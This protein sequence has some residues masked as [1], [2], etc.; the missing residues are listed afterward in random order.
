ML[1]QLRLRFTF[2]SHKSK[3]EFQSKLTGGTDV[4]TMS[5]ELG[6]VLKANGESATLVREVTILG[7]GATAHSA[8]FTHLSKDGSDTCDSDNDACR[9]VLVEATEQGFNAAQAAFIRSLGGLPDP[10]SSSTTAPSVLT[11]IK[12]FQLLPGGWDGRFEGVNDTLWVKVSQRYESDI[13]EDKAF[14]QEVSKV[15][16]P[17]EYSDNILKVLNQVSNINKFRSLMNGVKEHYV[18]GAGLNVALAEAHPQDLN[19][20]ILGVQK[21]YD[22]YRER[23]LKLSQDCLDEFTS[24]GTGSHLANKC[25]ANL[26]LPNVAENFGFKDGVLWYGDPLKNIAAQNL[27]M[28][29][30][31]VLA[32]PDNNSRA[33]LWTPF[34]SYSKPHNSNLPNTQLNILCNCTVEHDDKGWYYQSIAQF[35]DDD[36]TKPNLFNITQLHAWGWKN[37][38]QQN[39]NLG[40]KF[41]VPC[42]SFYIDDKPNNCYFKFH[43]NNGLLDNKGTFEFSPNLYFWD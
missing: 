7:G 35:N 15:E 2:Q 33:H 24:G 42:R 13:P 6:A 22:D 40:W 14:F 29:Q 18:Q 16:F 17:K 27:V 36:Y 31:N 43:H 25:A 19:D 20:N 5:N 1:A 28:L 11:D 32:N 9:K 38:W 8:Y 39:F 23:Q 30:Y 37:Q 10:T 34:I 41:D 12:N 4:A 21:K 3:E 26:Y